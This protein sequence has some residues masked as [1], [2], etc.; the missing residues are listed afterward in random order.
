MLISGTLT[1]QETY[2]DEFPRNS[3][4]IS[5]RKVLI[6]GHLHVHQM[7]NNMFALLRTID[8]DTINR[9]GR[10]LVVNEEYSNRE[11]KFPSWLSIRDW[12]LFEASSVKANMIVAKDGT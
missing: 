2:R 7:G 11:H 6:E 5:M 12:R 10:S 1:N 8:A 4:R 9:E 3:D